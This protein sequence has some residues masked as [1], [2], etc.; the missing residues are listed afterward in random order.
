MNTPAES[1]DQAL[2]SEE[3]RA[4]ALYRSRRDGGNQTY[5]S[6]EQVRRRLGLERKG[7]YPQQP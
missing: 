5:V 6:H 1:Q 7:R 2:A 4:L 3:A